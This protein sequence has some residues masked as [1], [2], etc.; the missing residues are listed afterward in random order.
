[1]ALLHYE[2]FDL[3]GNNLT[4]LGL[5][6]G[7]SVLGGTTLVTVPRTGSYSLQNAI[8]SG[9]RGL[10][11]SL[12]ASRSVAGQGVAMRI[13]APGQAGSLSQ[14]NGLRFGTATDN[15]RLRVNVNDNS[16]ISVFAGTTLLGASAN[17]IVPV[18][19][20]FWLE[21]MATS[22]AGT[23]GAV[24]VRLNGATILT[25]SGLSLTAD[26]TNVR[27]GSDNN[28]GGYTANFDDWIVWDNTGSDNNTFFGDTFIIV[29]DPNSDTAVNSFV[30]STGTDRFAMIDEA[31]PSDTDFLTANAAGDSQE[32]NTTTPTLPANGAIAAVAS[33]IRALKTTTGASTITHG[34]AVG[35]ASNVSA[36]INLGTGAVV[37]SHI[38]ERNPDGNV[39][40]TQTAAQAS[41]LRFNRTA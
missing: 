9:T 10:Q 29:A 28:A 32:L 18:N 14:M 16:G 35:A 22:G 7:Y 30:P 25:L 36:G 26:W 27:I 8:G 31:V 38:A 1:M 37:Y 19:T 41:R 2:H 5:R 3:Y 20:F 17:N 33:Q 39:V 11:W 21:A 15:A 4:N 6:P 23:A 34:I 40:W 12:P 13:N 24:E